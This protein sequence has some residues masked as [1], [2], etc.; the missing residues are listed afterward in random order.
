MFIHLAVHRPYTEK[1]GELAESMI[2]FGS[3]MQDQPGLQQVFT[4]RDQKTGAMIGLAL[5]DSKEAWEAARPAMLAAIEN[6]PFGEWEELPP[7]VFH[8]DVLWTN[9]P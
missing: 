5:W 4:L 6:D 7:D 2:R 3:A 9:K 8:L 1:A